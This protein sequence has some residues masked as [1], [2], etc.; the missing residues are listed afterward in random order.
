M[1]AR[2]VQVRQN[3]LG[4]TFLI[5]RTVYQLKVDVSMLNAVKSVLA[6]I[7]ALA[8]CQRKEL[9]LPSFELDDLTDTC[10]LTAS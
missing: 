3:S 7:R 5:K 9:S 1:P 2:L 4:T 6:D 10:W 8:L